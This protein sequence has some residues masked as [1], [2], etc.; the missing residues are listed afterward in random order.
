MVL[1]FVLNAASCVAVAGDLSFSLPVTT[2]AAAARQS[3]SNAVPNINPQNLSLNSVSYRYSTNAFAGSVM[4][5]FS[6]VFENRGP[7]IKP[8]PASSG[9]LESRLLRVSFSPSDRGTSRGIVELTRPDDTN[10]VGEAWVGSVVLLPSNAVHQSNK[11]LAIPVFDRHR[12]VGHAVAELLQRYPDLNRDDLLLSNLRVVN[13]SPKGNGFA[14]RFGRVVLWRRSSVERKETDTHI[15]ILREEIVV[16]TDVDSQ[17]SLN[18][19]VMRSKAR[20]QQRKQGSLGNV[21][22]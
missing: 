21:P 9:V 15:A 22:Q 13:D 10:G 20:D 1:L 14:K 19:R 18:V 3:I 7:A 4:E 12:F 5:G 8:H 2:L 6:V 17:G 11:T 16:R